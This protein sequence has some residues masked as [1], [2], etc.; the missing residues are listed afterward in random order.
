MTENNEDP[1]AMLTQGILGYIV[2]TSPNREIRFN[3][4]DLE[5]ARKDLGEGMVLDLE[6]NDDEMR[7]FYRAKLAKVEDKEES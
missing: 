4:K 2:A 1:V 6:M 7:L 3:A 5:D